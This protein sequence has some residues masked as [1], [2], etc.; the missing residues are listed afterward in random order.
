MA[1]RTRRTQRGT[2]RASKGRRRAARPGRQHQERAAHAERAAPQREE[3]Q[4]QVPR[5][6]WSGTISFGLVSVPVDLHAAV[7]AVRLPLRMLS[8]DGTPLQRR[9]FCPDEERDVAGDELARGYELAP[10]EHVVV[11]D[12]EL[13][14]LAPRASR[15]IDLRRFVPVDDID[16]FLFESSYVLAPTGDSSK[17]YRL[18][19]LVMEEEGRAGIATFVMRGKEHLVAILARNGILHAEV[20]R[21]ADE[22]RSPEDAGLPSPAK[23]PAELAEH[24]RR[25]LERLPS[26]LDLASLADEETAQLRDLVEEKRRRGVDV[27]EAHEVSAEAGDGESEAAPTDILAALKRS[28]ATGKRAP[29]ARRRRGA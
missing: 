20:L 15:D 5:P 4:R 3:P 10:D 21:F 27:V 8:E 24:F 17:A 25:A 11:T 6:F 29:Q 23:V 19:A 22:V 2:A 18:L 16:P 12:E 28:L 13:E 7:R 1:T 14:A 9:Y 26:K